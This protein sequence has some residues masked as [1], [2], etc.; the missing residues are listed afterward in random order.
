MTALILDAENPWPGLESFNESSATFFHGREAEVE[1]LVRALARSDLTVL[2][3]Q[4]GLGKTSV[5]Q[6]GLFPRLRR[7]DYLPIYIRLDFSEYSAGLIEQVKQ[8]L[9]E[10]AQEASFEAPEL[11]PE[12]GL[13]AAFQRRNFD[14]W[15]DRNRPVT[16]VLVFD[17]FEELFTL[18]AHAGARAR[19]TQGFL[20]ALACLVE[21]RVPSE[22]TKEFEKHPEAAEEFDFRKRQHKV[23]LAFREDFLPEIEGLRRLIPSIAQNRLRLLPMSVGQ[24]LQ[25]VETSGGALVTRIVAQRIVDFVAGTR[26]PRQGPETPDPPIAA[27]S[28]VEP[29]LLSVVCAEL[30]NRRKQAQRNAITVDL[31]EKAQEDI[32]ADFYTRSLAD[33]DSAVRAFIEDQ[34]LT[35]SGYR[36][37]Y[38]LEDALLL[39]SVTREA[40]DRLVG[41]RVLRL[42]ERSGLKRIELTH[43]LLAPVVRESRDKRREQQARVEA[44]SQARR[45][46]KERIGTVFMFGL[47][48]TVAVVFYVQKQSAEQQRQIAEQQR[49]RA[50]EQTRRAEEHK[51]DLVNGIWKLTDVIQKEQFS[52]STKEKFMDLLGENVQLLAKI[53]EQK[54]ETAE[55][56]RTTSVTWMLIGDIQLES[57]G[58]AAEKAYRRGLRID[59][60]LVQQNPRNRQWQRDLSVSYNKIGRALHKR[61]RPAEALEYYQ[62]GLDIRKRLVEEG[63]KDDEWR[64]GRD[65]A[66]NYGKIAEANIAL[67][68]FP[69]ALAAADQARVIRQALLDKCHEPCNED[70]RRL[71]DIDARI[72]TIEGRLAA[73][74]GPSR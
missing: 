33:L 40:I 70:R 61:N 71:A 21:N 45:R 66:F 73:T 17:Q 59:Q 28:C 41:R 22:L 10:A 60:R 74:G 36:N 23:L 32:I 50:D 15:S 27:D 7:E 4:S 47:M 49:Q 51:L 64:G 65:L 46:R 63:L 62:K 68:A 14:L 34:L 52:P 53:T 56:L 20:A 9:R 55:V 39:S 25:V 54:S 67:N 8:R 43:D 69:A 12:D 11:H 13:W 38:A 3:G 29:A 5:L 1:E 35:S 31:L 48:V 18:G 37:S 6:A 30:N 72:Y 44:E 2:Y 58:K 57:D 26:G 16:P 42:E 24:A 19:E